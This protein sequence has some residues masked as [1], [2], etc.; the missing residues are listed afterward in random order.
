MRR[1][2]V[3]AGFGV[4]AKSPGSGTV[5]R[6][7]DARTHPEN[8][9]VFAPI[10]TCSSSPTTVSHSSSST[11]RSAQVVVVEKK[12]GRRPSR[13]DDDDDDDDDGAG[14]EGIEPRGSETRVEM[15]AASLD[16]DASARR[17]IPDASRHDR[18]ISGALPTGAPRVF[19]SSACEVTHS[20]T[21]A[22]QPITCAQL[23]CLPLPLFCSS[24]NS[25]CLGE[26]QISPLGR[27]STTAASART[28]SHWLVSTHV[29]T[30]Y[31][32]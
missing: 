1:H 28:P 8:S 30:R 27:G 22:S 23:A 24:R 26:I 32:R 25:N 16:R 19:V 21:F 4:A 3:R 20:H 5:R 17:S 6:G 10:C 18:A 14:G 15:I 31:G 12:R 2:R 11:G 13:D 9:L 29:P 7:T